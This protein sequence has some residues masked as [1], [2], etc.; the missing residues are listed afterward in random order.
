MSFR[1]HLIAALL[2]AAIATPAS[3]R[4]FGGSG[5][6]DEYED[7][8]EVVIVDGKTLAVDPRT[9]VEDAEGRRLDLDALDRRVGR[10]VRFVAVAGFPHPR[11]TL[12]VFEDPIEDPSGLE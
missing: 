3:A 12:L 2:L 9:R 7:S 8:R 1:H 4:N 5:D 6:L 10:H 11:A